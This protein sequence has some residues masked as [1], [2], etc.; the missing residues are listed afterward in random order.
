MAVLAQEGSLLDGMEILEA[1]GTALFSQ[2]VGSEPGAPALTVVLPMK[3]PR[4]AAYEVRF[5][6]KPDAAAQWTRTGHRNFFL[7][8]FA[9]GLLAILSV[10]LWV[11]HRRNLALQQGILQSGHLS[12]LGLMAAAMAHELRNPLSSIRGLSQVLLETHPPE[13][14]EHLDTI[15][16]E[17]G[18]ME[19]LVEDLLLFARPRDPGHEVVPIGPLLRSV[20]EELGLAGRVRI[21]TP[22]GLKARGDGEQLRQVFFNLLKNAAEALSRG[23]GI[24]ISGSARGKT[25]RVA[26]RNPAPGLAASDLDHFFTPFHTTKSRGTGLGLF[27]SSRLVQRHGGTLSAELDGTGWLTLEVVLPRG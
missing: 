6:F 8:L 12:E 18:R 19:R 22:D 16:R 27:L 26:F 15:V 3:G 11:M 17:T 21:Q 24:E 9:A 2:S 14:K 4:A 1:N 7:A 20:A 5:L 23:E 25:A 10:L 13:E